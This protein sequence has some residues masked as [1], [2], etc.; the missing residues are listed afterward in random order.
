[1]RATFAGQV[2]GGGAMTGDTLDIVEDGVEEQRDDPAEAPETE[3]ASPA[4]PKDLEIFLRKAVSLAVAYA[5]RPTDAIIPALAHASSIF[6]VALFC[7][8]FF[9]HSPVI[10]PI[11]VPKHMAEEE[12]VTS[13]IVA[14]RLRDQM[15]LLIARADSSA[16]RKGKA[17]KNK[18]DLP[19]L[20]V[21]S[22]GISL[23]SL[24][25]TI[26]NFLHL[27]R[28]PVLTGEVTQT[29]DRVAMQLRWNGQVIY[30]TDETDPIP[31]RFEDLLNDAAW[32]AVEQWQP[33]F[34]ALLTG[35]HDP[36]AGIAKLNEIIESRSADKSN[37]L[38]AIY[39]KASF[40]VQS[41]RLD[42]A[43][44]L[45]DEAGRRDPGSADLHVGW[46][47]LD[48]W[49]GQMD[50][51]RAHL[52]RAIKREAAD[53]DPYILLGD[54][55]WD[56]D[57]F[58]AA[59][60]EYEKALEV[61][62]SSY[63]TLIRMGDIDLDQYDSL[64]DTPD[65]QA[66]RQRLLDSSLTSYNQAL[67]INVRATGAHSGLGQLYLSQLRLSPD[68]AVL[69]DKARNEFALVLA[70]DSDD[71]KARAAYADILKKL[72]CHP[73]AEQQFA[74][75]TATEPKTI[76]DISALAHT[77]EDGVDWERSIELYSRL[78]K[79]EPSAMQRNLHLRLAAVYTVHDQ[80]VPA[81]QQLDEIL[82]SAPDDQIALAR[83]AELLKDNPPSDH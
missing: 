38:E 68:D 22:V 71:L 62:P 30:R 54:W 18:E 6:A 5:K 35:T 40:L 1:M 11:S 32:A 14:D 12:G 53:P 47:Y 26:G 61:N 81:E 78:L 25:S 7:S 63:D 10:Q 66:L 29:G 15:S 58:D 57:K 27:S 42:D 24:V 50:D 16:A 33:Q 23:Q 17:V 59:R 75:V 64:Q 37:I 2:L 72:H 73:D 31:K 74:K 65:N 76:N 80:N 28:H 21:P 70:Q 41:G 49:R 79:M 77:L 43:E 55:L 3:P 51:A 4:S 48:Y 83:K 60:A 9:D 52:Q 56:D 46:A 44:A 39:Y 34:I 36:Q 82:K 45:L 67:S 13:E 20:S 8:A 19:D 69:L